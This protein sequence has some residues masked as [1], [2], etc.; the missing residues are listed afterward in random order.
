M[1]HAEKAREA[2]VYLSGSPETEDE[3]PAEWSVQE[4]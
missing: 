1:G 4:E 3:V 2:D